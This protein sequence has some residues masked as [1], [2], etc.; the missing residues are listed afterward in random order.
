MIEIE[1][2]GTPAVLI[3]SG[4]FELGTIASAKVWGMP[5]IRYVVVPR[6]F[7]NLTVPEGIEQT[8]QAFDVLV[9][10]LTTNVNGG[11]TATAGV[12]PESTEWTARGQGKGVRELQAR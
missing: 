4:R 6:I 1:K 8:E 3:V 10:E 7:R 2:Q 5:D 9:Q 11:S 12:K